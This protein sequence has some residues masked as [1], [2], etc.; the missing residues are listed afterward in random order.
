MSGDPGHLHQPLAA[1]TILGLVLVSAIAL[2]PR[3]QAP[4]IVYNGSGSAPIGWYRVENRQPL[5]GDFVIVAPSKTL[6][7]LLVTH[8][9]VPT[10]VPLLKRVVATTGDRV[11]RSGALVTVNGEIFAEALERD[12][13][14]HSMPIWEG[15]LTIFEGQFFLLQPHPYSFDSRYF[16]PVSE[17]Q[18]IGVVTPLWTWNPDE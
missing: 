4:W 14:G 10:G 17:C 7:R 16:G 8:T 12:Q 15:C 6:E 3:S 13:Y 11:C 18:I 1:L 5:P 9:V 2:L